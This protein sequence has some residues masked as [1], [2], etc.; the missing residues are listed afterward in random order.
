VL[1]TEVSALLEAR[2]SLRGKLPLSGKAQSQGRRAPGCRRTRA[3][4]QA[5]GRR[6]VY[7]QVEVSSREDCLGS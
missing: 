5:H 7:Q 1:L 4:W 2:R 6:V 3:K